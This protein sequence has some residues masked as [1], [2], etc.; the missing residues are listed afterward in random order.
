[1][2][3]EQADAGARGV[4]QATARVNRPHA[5]LNGVQKRVGIT[6]TPLLQR[7]P[8]EFGFTWGFE[9]DEPDAADEFFN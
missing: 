5:M 2:C 4:L 9:D 6:A 1:M 7:K 3:L 8:W